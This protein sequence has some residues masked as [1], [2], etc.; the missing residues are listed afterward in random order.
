MLSS[1]THTQ[2]HQEYL[3]AMV[4][5]VTQA[6]KVPPAVR[7][8]LVCLDLLGLKERLVGKDLLVSRASMELR[9]FKGGKE[10]QDC[11]EERV[12]QVHVYLKS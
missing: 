7:D 9:G 10:Y 2:E 6:H 12:C 3:V 5:M 11:L 8:H 4:L 1:H